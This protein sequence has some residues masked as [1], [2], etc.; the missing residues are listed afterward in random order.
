[1]FSC[2]T[3]PRFVHSVGD[4]IPFG[5]VP[6]VQRNKPGPLFSILCSITEDTIFDSLQEEEEETS[7]ESISI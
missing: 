3:P 2:A 6:P 7:T 1:M 4:I 5:V